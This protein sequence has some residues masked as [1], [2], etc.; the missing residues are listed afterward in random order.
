MKISVPL[1]LCFAAVVTTL[2]P[3]AG[4]VVAR[5]GTGQE[6]E[7]SH[8][9][10]PRNSRVAASR[11]DV[12]S[13]PDLP[14][15]D[16]DG[17]QVRFYSDLVKGKTVVMNFVFTSCTTICPPMGANF[18]RLQEMLGERAGEDVHLIS[19]SVDP[20][21]DTPTRLKAWREKFGGASG[22]TLVTG[23][24]PQITDLLKAL[25]VFSPDPEDHAPLLLLGDDA[26]GNWRK[27]N[28]LAPPSKLME[29]LDGMAERSQAASGEGNDDAARNYF[30]DTVLLDQDG[31]EVRFYSDILEDKVVVI[32][33]LFTS[34]TGSC[35]M[36]ARTFARLQDELGER[37]GSKVH[38]VSITVDPEMDTPAR[39]REYGERFDR[40]P[41]WTFLT[42][43]KENVDEVLYKLGQYVDDPEQ[44]LAAVL[45]G[46]EPA[47]VWQKAPGLAPA[48]TLL[49]GVE[50]IL[51]AGR[52]G[53]AN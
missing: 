34:C 36:M 51:A 15:L 9:P 41:G 17:Q 13:I 47:G 30:T 25:G 5:A 52:P 12:P 23:P 24:K 48:A 26:A 3:S 14:L 39:L 31:R 11:A 16:Q 29:I 50:E 32:N 1:S 19:V 28:G 8:H 6:G 40:R 22:W 46:N 45:I 35:P 7:H 27:L 44:H 49:A 38:L 18:G 20:E 33:A 37:L 4:A 53:V 43:S 42:G 21:T 2:A 10:V